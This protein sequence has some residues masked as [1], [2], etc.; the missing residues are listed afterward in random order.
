M[1]AEIYKDEGCKLMGTAFEFYNERGY[2]INF[3]HKESTEWKRLI[4]SE[5]IPSLAPSSAE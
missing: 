4:L 1:K 2:F 3:G 5:F